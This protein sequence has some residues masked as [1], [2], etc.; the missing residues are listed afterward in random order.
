MRQFERAA[1]QLAKQLFDIAV[2]E[3]E[4]TVS[5]SK[6]DILDRQEDAVEVLKA[7]KTRAQRLSPDVRRT[8][9]R[10]APTIFHST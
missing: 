10:T 7:G 2:G 8:P 4:D 1:V 6:A 5:E 9:E 3:T